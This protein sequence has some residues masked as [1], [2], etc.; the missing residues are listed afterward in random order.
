[1]DFFDLAK[2]D[3]CVDVLCLLAPLLLIP[4]LRRLL[5][6]RQLRFFLNFLYEIFRCC[7]RA[8]PSASLA[9]CTNE[10]RR[11]GGRSLPQVL[12]LP[13]RRRT[14][15]HRHRELHPF[16]LLGHGSGR[17]RTRRRLL[18]ARLALSLR[19]SR[20]RAGPGS[21]MPRSSGPQ[22]A[23]PA[24]SAQCRVLRFRLALHGPPL[25]WSS[26]PDDT[27]CFRL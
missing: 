1:M 5:S 6:P 27:G 16:R 23:L 18:S 25:A 21:R 20:P 15:R 14:A 12:A 10:T 7:S 8:T 4:G 24:Q 2:Y 22:R 19:R 13:P 26:T 11:R 9:V 3:A 17:R